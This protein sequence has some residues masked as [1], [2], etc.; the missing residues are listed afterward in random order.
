LKL[1]LQKNRNRI[2]H[3]LLII[4]CFKF[5]SFIEHVCIQKDLVDY[6]CIIIEEM[7]I[8][9]HIY[10]IIKNLAKEKFKTSWI[11]VNRK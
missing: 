9:G 6:I 10:I 3:L 4:G 1:S 5:L 11:L 7:K 8:Q 2:K